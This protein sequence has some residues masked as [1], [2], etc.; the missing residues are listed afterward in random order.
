MAR[1]NIACRHSND[2]GIARRALAP[3]YE[4]SVIKSLGS[5]CWQPG[6]FVANRTTSDK[7]ISEASVGLIATPTR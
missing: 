1:A 5:W 4:F 3:S 2:G 6:V 7:I